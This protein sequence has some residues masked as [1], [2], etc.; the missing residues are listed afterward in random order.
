MNTRDTACPLIHRHRSRRRF[1]GET[2]ALATGLYAGLGLRDARAADFLEA[3]G[4]AR[5]IMGPPG[6]AP[7]QAA[8]RGLILGPGTFVRPDN[9]FDHFLCVVD[10]DAVTGQT[11]TLHRLPLDFFGH[12][13]VFDPRYPERAVVLQKKGEGACEVDLRAGTVLRPIETAA[14]RKFYGHGAFSPDGALLYCTETIEA[15]G[16]RGLVS[17]RDARSHEQLGAFPSH[18]ASPHDCQLIDDGRVL[19]ITNGGGPRG[20]TAPSVTYVDVKTEKLIEKLEFATPDINAG[21]LA[22]SARGDL[23]VVS[24]QRDGLPP[25]TSPGGIS[26]RP[27][28]GTW[29][30]LTQ[31][32]SLL[33]RL[34]G[35]T[36]SVC[37]DEAHGVVAATTPVGNRLTFWDMASGRLLREYGAHNPRGVTLT[38]DGGHFVVSY[39]KPPHLS[40]IS[41]E[42][43]DKTAN[44]D[45]AGTGMSGSHIFTTVLPVGDPASTPR[46]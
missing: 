20:G 35:E 39:D 45:L 1:L 13:V 23:A 26:L 32:A 9:G 18:G 46:A 42:T 33:S 24:A 19:V 36:L 7:S 22:I 5:P 14:D 41:T 25:E 2:L 44:L 4:A 29:H 11:Y 10:L 8:V 16:Y 3:L 17:V 40:L 21:H 6:I 31:P 37:I 38:R 34:Y 15:A 12:G 30:T 43:L 27:A 28:G